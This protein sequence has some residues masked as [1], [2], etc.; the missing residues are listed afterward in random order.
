MYKILLFFLSFF[1]FAIYAQK[2]DNDS[3]GIWDYPVKPGMEEWY[4]L[5]TE[6]DRIA[7]LQVPED[8]LSTL[9]PGDAVRLCITF[10]SFFIFTA[11]NTPQEGFN[12]MLSRY[13]IL[14][15]FL[16]RDDVGSSLIAA[17]KDAGLSGFKTLQYSN[18]FWSFKLF[19]LELLLSQKE[20]LQSLNPEE[21]LELIKEARYK[22]LYKISNDNFSSLPGLLFSLK[23][24][25]GILDVDEYEELI[26]S[27]NRESITRFMNTGWWFDDIPPIDEIFKITENYINVKNVNNEKI[28]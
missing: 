20:F 24:M 22:F 15:H 7:I 27:L 25:S 6:D 26:T 13:N 19:F 3:N 4:L 21:K 14:K 5:E 10:P 16:S 17:Y 11:F 1:S 9:S 12:I 8:I 28:N 23:I 2:S 18:E